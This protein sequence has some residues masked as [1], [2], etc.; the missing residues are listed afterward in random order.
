MNY[1]IGDCI[2]L[3]NE[4]TYIVLNNYREGDIEY[5]LISNKD[6]AIDTFI[7]EVKENAD[8][9]K[10]IKDKEKIEEIIKNMQK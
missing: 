4:E 1:E 10:T 2:K 5:Y 6:K 7:V 8:K 3:D 9:L